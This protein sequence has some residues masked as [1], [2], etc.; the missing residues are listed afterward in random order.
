M[1]HMM[2]VIILAAGYVGVLQGAERFDSTRGYKFSTYVQY[3]IRKSILRVVA[4]YARGIVIPWS[5]NRAINQIQ[6]ARKAMKSTHKKC[7][8]D[9]EI[10]K[11]TGLSLDKI[12][13][14]SNCLRIVASI[15]QKVGD[16]LGV[17]Y[18][19]LLPDA[20]IESPE[21]AVMKQHMRKDVHDLLKGLNLRERKILT[22][23][24][25]LNDNQPRSL[26]D[27]GT[28]FKV[29]KERIRKIE[30]KALTKLKNEATISKLHYYLDL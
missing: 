30:K 28:L 21:D 18:M 5:L 17:E 25:G 23:R 24:F 19:E 4:R 15:D 1:L 9:Y 6:K 29:S 11:M 12:K 20:T 14:A 13:S 10:A 26:Q 2:N 8:D 3:W 16:Y 7:P 22:L 27:I